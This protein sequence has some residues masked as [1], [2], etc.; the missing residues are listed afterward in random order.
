LNNEK[1][2]IGFRGKKLEIP[3]KKVSEIGKGVGL[4]FSLRKNA[5]ALLFEFRNPKKISIHSLFVFF[6]FI[7]LWLDDKNNVIDMRK[8]DPFTLNIS[9][10][11][12]YFRLL[13]IPFNDNY[14]EIISTLVDR[15]G[16]KRI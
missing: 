7:A 2:Q 13:E 16:L 12:P 11:K 15:K 14:K 8:I 4:M 9:S 1:I 10:R 6:P 5:K 3:I